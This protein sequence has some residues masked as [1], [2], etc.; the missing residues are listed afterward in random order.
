MLGKVK[1][2][3]LFSLA[4]GLPT[5]L[6]GCPSTRE[7]IQ[8]PTYATLC[9]S[10]PVSCRN[11]VYLF[12][13]NGYDL[14]DCGNLE[15]LACQL[16]DLGY[17]KTYVG[18]FNHYEYFY[19]EIQN[20]HHCDPLARFVMV[21]SGHGCLHAS[22]LARRAA[23]ARIPV[24]LLLCLDGDEEGVARY[25]HPAVSRVVHIHGEKCLAETAKKTPGEHVIIPKAGHWDLATR[26]E[27][28]E[29]V[30]N[31]ITVVA[32]HVELVH[33]VPLSP[34]TG[35]ALDTVDPVAKNEKDDWDFLL[36]KSA[37]PHFGKEKADYAMDSNKHPLVTDPTVDGASPTKKPDDGTGPL[38]R[39]GLQP[40]KRYLI[41][42]LK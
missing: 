35:A 41:D 16:N 4:V 34:A 29:T 32:S 42:D 10:M 23:S 30:V 24:D 7:S 38:K 36:V 37:V 39:P 28:I 22:E 12:C 31:E 25:K 2:M 3:A 13:L 1:Q 17:I 19:N 8:P 33:Y 15:G 21:G 5:V 40:G 6:S 14:L 26:P 11:H 9:Q 27:T 20:I 18:Y